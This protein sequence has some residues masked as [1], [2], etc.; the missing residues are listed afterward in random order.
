MAVRRG[1]LRY[2]AVPEPT[3]LMT[4]VLGLLPFGFR[5]RRYRNTHG[6]QTL[7]LRLPQL[8]AAVLIA[9]VG[10]EFARAQQPFF[11]GL[12]DLPGGPT[13][14][15]ATDVSHD[16]SVVTG[17]SVTDDVSSSNGDLFRWTRE[18]GMT[19]LGAIHA[20]NF[21]EISA[22][23]S[24]IIGEADPTGGRCC[25]NEYLF[26]WTHPTGV[27]PLQFGGHRAI[28]GIG[29]VNGDGTI[30]VGWRN[31]SSLSKH[32][33]VRWTESRGVELLFTEISSEVALDISAD[34][35]VILGLETYTPGP[36]RL[37]IA[38][39]PGGITVIEGTTQPGNHGELELSDNGQVVIGVDRPTAAEPSVAFRWTKESGLTYL[40]PLPDGKRTASVRGLSADGSVI[41]GNSEPD[42]DNIIIPPGASGWGVAREPYIWDEMHGVRYL[43]DVL[44]NDYGLG[45][46]R[47]QPALCSFMWPFGSIAWIG[48]VFGGSS[49]IDRGGWSR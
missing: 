23:G 47:V 7:R 5:R 19:S 28:G 42:P 18:T 9:G 44:K 38:T 40:G 20:Y 43:F 37:F 27:V 25:D 1:G 24:T 26:R 35:A 13:I 15:W 8:F 34:G 21:P 14:S 17:W 32:E 39:E 4:A 6:P 33:A 3:T 30:V 45:T 31:H 29:G 49:R 48:V 11:M 10:A 2:L 46:A 12:G 22:D 36:P 41:V 16:G